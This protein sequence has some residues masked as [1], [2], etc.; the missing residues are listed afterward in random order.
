MTE[1]SF[2]GASGGTIMQVK[3]TLQVKWEEIPQAL[4][5]RYCLDF[6]PTLG[7]ITC[8]NGGNNFNK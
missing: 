1:Y 7:L 6:H 2:H 5:D 4:I 8:N 3:T